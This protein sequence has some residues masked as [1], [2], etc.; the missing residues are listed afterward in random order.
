MGPLEDPGRWLEGGQVGVGL[1]EGVVAAALPLQRAGHLLRRLLTEHRPGLAELDGRAT[2]RL[3]LRQ[4]LPAEGGEGRGR[5][6][7]YKG[8]GGPVNIPLLL[9][10]LTVVLS[11]RL[12]LLELLLTA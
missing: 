2:R 6:D 3:R 8:G 1:A 7:G 12:A 11:E 5:S 10:R 4:A 9:N